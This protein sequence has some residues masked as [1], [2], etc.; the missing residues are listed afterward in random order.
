VAKN[1]L[2]TF[3]FNCSYILVIRRRFI[4]ISQQGLF[5]WQKFC[6]FL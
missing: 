4:Y 2:T 1:S 5:T 3:Y 6:V